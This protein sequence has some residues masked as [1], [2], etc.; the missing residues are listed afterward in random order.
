MG[1]DY[2][3]GKAS[4]ATTATAANLHVLAIFDKICSNALAKTLKQQIF[5][6]QGSKT[7]FQKTLV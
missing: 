6:C 4:F 2:K 7:G 1:K 3:K 5:A